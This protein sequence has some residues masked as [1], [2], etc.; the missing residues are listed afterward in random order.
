MKDDLNQRVFVLVAEVLRCDPAKVSPQARFIEDLEANSLDVV[1][2]AC[3][4]E[5]EFCLHF[6][7]AQIANIRTVGDLIDALRQNLPLAPDGTKLQEL[8]ASR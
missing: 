3:L 8:P 6:H 5:G 1:E 2:L 7:E 4:V